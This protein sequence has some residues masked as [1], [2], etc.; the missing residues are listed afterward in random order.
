VSPSGRITVV[1]ACPEGGWPYSNWPRADEPL[2]AQHVSP[3]YDGWLNSLH[4][5]RAVVMLRCQKPATELPR[6]LSTMGE[7]AVPVLIASPAR[8]VDQVVA[9]FRHGATSYL[10][11]GDYTRRAL[12]AAIMS[13]AAGHTHLSPAACAALMEGMTR[14]APNR[15]GMVQLRARLSPR[16]R[17]IMELLVDGCRVPEI[18]R[19]L[20]LSEE[21]VRNNL[22]SIFAKLGAR[23]RTEAAL[24]WLGTGPHGEQRGRSSATT[25]RARRGELPSPADRLLGRRP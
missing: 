23:S 12:T 15:D 10:I 16:E 9:A 3:P 22:S 6:L 1:V 25:T 2:R 19:R 14:L 18:G 11:D 5:T 24:I 17:Q 13:T 7:K 21:T 20:S 4:D 8:D